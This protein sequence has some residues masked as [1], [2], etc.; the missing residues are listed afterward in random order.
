MVA[1]ETDHTE[2]NLGDGDEPALISTRPITASLG[3]NPLW[4]EQTEVQQPNLDP[5]PD[6]GGRSEIARM[7]LMFTLWASVENFLYEE[8][9]VEPLSVARDEK[10][11][12]S[13]LRESETSVICLLCLLNDEYYSAGK[14]VDAMIGEFATADQRGNARKRL[15]N[16]T[17]PVIGERYGLLKSYEVG[18]GSSREYRI[19]RSERLIRFADTH[20]VTGV[21]RLMGDDS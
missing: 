2:P 15:I 10:K 11:H 5:I 21:R 9:Q 14:L 13:I 12:L 4:S 20:L 17:L 3:V 18:Q 7:A 1:L 19:C 16:R 6:F 8:E